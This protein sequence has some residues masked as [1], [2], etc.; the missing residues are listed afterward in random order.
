MPVA[1]LTEKPESLVV[2]YSNNY[3]NFNQ[4]R[5]YIANT[6]HIKCFSRS[7]RTLQFAMIEK[8]VLDT[9][10][11]Y[12]EIP[13]ASR[14]VHWLVKHYIAAYKKVFHH[15]Q[16]PTLHKA[17][18]YD[19][20]AVY[21]ELLDDIFTHK[22]FP[23]NLSKWAV[24]VAEAREYQEEAKAADS[25]WGTVPLGRLQTL[26]DGSQDIDEDEVVEAQAEDAEELN[27][28]DVDVDVDIG[29]PFQGPL[30]H[31][32]VT[33]DDASNSSEEDAPYTVDS[34]LI[35]LMQRRLLKR[36]PL[37]EWYWECDLDPDCTFVINLNSPHRTADARYM[38]KL[39]EE[40]KAFLIGSSWRLLDKKIRRIWRKICQAHWEEHMEEVGFT[41]D[42]ASRHI[43][44]K[45]INE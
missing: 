43:V 44:E 4:Q 14:D 31:D 28:M 1:Y 27:I 24:W 32:K 35:G 10:K 21:A 6:L 12:K 29:D 42:H 37:P 40:E 30:N 18:I 39:S 41:I 9:T 38:A 11:K 2:V 20:F 8:F 33:L 16:R 22:I 5:C 17:A 36:M 34:N 26:P 3:N 19:Y 25:E 13:R 15:R 23:M 7:E 45:Y